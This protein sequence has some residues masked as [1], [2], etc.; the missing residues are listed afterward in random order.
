VWTHL[1]KELEMRRELETKGGNEGK[2]KG[3]KKPKDGSRI[4]G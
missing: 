3:N 1:R 4:F 2:K